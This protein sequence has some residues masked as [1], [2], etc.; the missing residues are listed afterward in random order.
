[1]DRYTKQFR[2]DTFAQPHGPRTQTQTP[3]H[4]YA[5]ALEQIEIADES[6]LD[7]NWLLA[8]SCYQ[9]AIATLEK[10]PHANARSLKDALN[11]LAYVHFRLFEFGEAYSC[12]RRAHGKSPALDDARAS[13][14]EAIMRNIRAARKGKID[15]NT[16]YQPGFYINSHF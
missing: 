5:H 15:N 7:E 12:F 14:A 4:P 9:S 11:R 13:E 1:M 8:K 3:A 10:M 2:A 16:D 6:L